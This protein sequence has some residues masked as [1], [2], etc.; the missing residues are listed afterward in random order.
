MI[1]HIH[2]ITYFHK[3]SVNVIKILKGAFAAAFGMQ[4]RP[5][6]AGV[7]ALLHSAF[8]FIAAGP[9]MR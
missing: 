4:K 2:I 8:G 3:T 6:A 7:R 9:K 1:V 5:C